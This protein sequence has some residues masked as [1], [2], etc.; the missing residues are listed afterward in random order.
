MLATAASFS[1]IAPTLVEGP[2]EAIID[3]ATAKAHLRVDAADD[4]EVIGLLVEAATAR[5]DGWS[6]ILGRCLVNQTWACTFP[7]FPSSYRERLLR[8]PLAPVSSI[9]SV[10]YIDAAGAEQTLDPATYRLLVDVESPFVALAPLASWPSTDRRD[11][12][13]TVAFVAGY[14]ESGDAVPGPIR[15]AILSMVADAFEFRESAAVGVSATDIPVSVT[16]EEMLA[17]YRRQGF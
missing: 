13:V 14:G 1:Q 9:A 11:D 6:G 3:L 15:Q 7:R 4:D 12:A 2:E 8:L 17:P 5:L 16:V 10:T